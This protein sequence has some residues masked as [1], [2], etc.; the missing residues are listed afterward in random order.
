MIVP[1]IFNVYE[2]SKHEPM[3]LW[4]FYK[5]INFCKDN[6]M[7]IIA[8]EEMFEKPSEFAKK[9]HPSAI[10]GYLGYQIP[11]D[12]DIE[13][14]ISSIITTT[15]TELLINENSDTYETQVTLISKRNRKF[16]DIIEDKIN[17]I[18]KKTSKKIEAMIVWTSF[19]SLQ[20]VCKKRGITLINYELSTIREGL[21]NDTLG[22]FSF[23]NKY[24]AK[25]LQSG[26]E[27]IK[28]EKI[29]LLGRREILGLFLK[30]DGLRYLNAYYDVPKYDIGIGFG[31]DKDAFD[32]AY[33]VYKA[34][35]VLN[36]ISKLVSAERVS[37]RSHP[38]FPRDLSKVNFIEDKSPNS[39]EWILSNRRIVSTV[40]NVGYEAMLYGKTSYVISKYMPFHS[41]T[42]N[43]IS[44]LDEQIVDIKYL[45]YITFG[46]YTPFELMF[47]MEYIKWRL[48]NPSSLD[49]YNKNLNH[50]LEKKSVADVFKKN[51]KDRLRYIL[52][53]VH[54]LDKNE[55]NIY[56][57]YK[58]STQL[59]EKDLAVENANSIIEEKNNQIQ[60]LE[61]GNEVLEKEINNILNSQSWKVTKPLRWISKVLK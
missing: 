11:S 28:G 56:E 51:S 30:T 48:T 47:N 50:V 37:V 1:F 9:G 49:I 31:L 7:P 12:S 55:S 45:N 26:Y 35:E 4:V 40:S 13:N 58:Y 2:Y 46:F 29:N 19:P 38:A 42:I 5:F 16:E 17:E 32:E 60:K 18:E 53:K 20:F 36:N 52:K 61:K 21:Y 27:E 34:E 59:I 57:E 25:Q 43:D 6:N 54:D 15:E 3:M 33:S 22:Y 10:K 24:D 44:Y 14:V 8:Q 41:G 23:G 39:V